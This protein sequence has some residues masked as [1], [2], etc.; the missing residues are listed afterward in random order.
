[1]NDVA[2]CRRHGRRGRFGR[3]DR[4]GHLSRTVLSACAQSCRDGCVHS[5]NSAIRSVGHRLLM[6]VLILGA[7][8]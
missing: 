5:R 1:V 2:A 7:V 3:R 4:D 8:H 6:L